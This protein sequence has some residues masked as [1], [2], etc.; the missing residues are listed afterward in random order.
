MTQGDFRPLV[1]DT[2]KD[3]SVMPELRVSATY[4]PP[5]AAPPQPPPSTVESLTVVVEELRSRVGELERVCHIQKCVNHKP[6][7]SGVYIY[8]ENC[9]VQLNGRLGKAEITD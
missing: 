9:G 7:S 8:C 6:V 2:R 1:E 5:S 4:E 3:R